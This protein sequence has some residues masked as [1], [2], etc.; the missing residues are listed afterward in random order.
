MSWVFFYIHACLDDFREDPYLEFAF[1]ES[2]DGSRGALVH[3]N[4]LC[5]EPGED[6][7]HHI[8][9]AAAAHA[10][11]ILFQVLL[12]VHPLKDLLH[13]IDH[14]VMVQFSLNLFLQLVCEPVQ[15]LIGNIVILAGLIYHNPSL[16]A[17]GRNP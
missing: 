12:Q 4:I 11:V 17:I 8:R 5:R 16:I 10:Y 9:L 15:N 2:D 3:H 13:H 7:G 1:I 6:K 14:M